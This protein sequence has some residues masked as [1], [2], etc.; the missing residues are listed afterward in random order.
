[1]TRV[2]HDEIDRLFHD[3]AASRKRSIRNRLVE[4]HTGFAHHLARRYANKGVADEDLHQVALLA[5]VKAVERFDPDHGAAFTTF[6]GRTIEGELK[7]YFRDKSWVVSVPR[8]TK[9]RHTA[10]RHATDALRT[11]LG[12]APTAREVATHLDITIDQVIETS[13]TA[14]AFS[15]VSLDTPGQGGQTAPAASSGVMASDDLTPE[16]AVERV[17]VDQLLES[18]PERD[19]EIIRLRYFDEMTQS[20][21]AEQMGI[22][23]MHVSRLLRRSLVLLKA[24]VGG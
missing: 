11:E 6:A 12:R 15:P 7:R 10:I 22:S 24:Q 2:N 3:Y 8:S 5:L 4:E 21:I 9:E 20:E 18:L 1:M 14:T 19:A 13:A 16:R 23:Q 17:M